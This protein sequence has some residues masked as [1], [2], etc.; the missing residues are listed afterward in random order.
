[1]ET[2]VAGFLA[3]SLVNGPRN[4]AVVFFS[5][6]KHDCP[7]CHNKEMQDFNYGELIT[8]DEIVEKIEQS[9]PLIK[10]VT[11]SGGDPFEQPEALL[12]LVQRI[13]DLGLDIWVYTGY[14]IDEL[15]SRFDR[16]ITGVLDIIDVLV[17]G[18]FIED[19]KDNAP[20]HVGSSNQRIIHLKNYK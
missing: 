11:I 19:M 9:M 1:M 18:R 4:R 14:T 16:N 5:G 2:R 17:D 20:K 3:D 13:R 12:E 15:R 6:C 7:G 10:G 8:T